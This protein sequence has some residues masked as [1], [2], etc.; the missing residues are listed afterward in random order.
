M[1]IERLSFRLSAPI[2]YMFNIHRP[3]MF[4]RLLSY[5]ED[6][7]PVDCWDIRSTSPS[8]SSDEYTVFPLTRNG[9]LKVYCDMETD[10]G[11]WTVSQYV[12]FSIISLKQ[13]FS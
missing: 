4:F 10:N 1:S 13:C 8:G 3:Y 5:S 2:P 11:G 12:I 6:I 7:A 9:P